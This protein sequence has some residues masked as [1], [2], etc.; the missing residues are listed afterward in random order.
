MNRHQD[1]FERVLVFLTDWSIGQVFGC[2]EK[3]I[4]EWKSGDC[5]T[6]ETSDQHFF[7]TRMRDGQIYNCNIGFKG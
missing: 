1:E 7:S 4:T 5:Y 3:S 6:F 2:E